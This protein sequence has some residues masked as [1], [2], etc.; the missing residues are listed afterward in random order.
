MDWN[1]V[2]HFL[3]LAR[4]RSARGAGASLGVSHSTVAR[5]VEALEAELGVRLFDRHRDGYLLTDAGELIV[6]AA[7]RIEREMAALERGVAGQDTRLEGPVRITCTDPFV[8][9]MLVRALAG[10]CE[11]HPGLEIELDA[12]SRYLDLSKREADVAVRAMAREATPPEHLLGRKIVPIVIASYVAQTRADRLDPERAGSGARWIGS[13]RT[14]VFE[15][16]VASSSYPDLPLWGAFASL[17]ML[18][19]ATREGMGI[20]MLPTYVGDTDRTL[21][22]LARPDVRHVGDF[23]LLSHP[24]L[25]ENARVRAARECVATAVTTLAPLFAG[26]RPLDRWREDAPERPEDAPCE[27]ATSPVDLLET[28]GPATKGPGREG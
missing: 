21:R 4:T 18:V 11:R 25:R 16:L 6:P 28:D 7:E 27:S 23:W 15:A 8:G 10:L 5:R 3:A 26:D 19:E 14:R 13:D 1:D 9:R 17:E 12:D 2:R 22:R 24:D 20:V